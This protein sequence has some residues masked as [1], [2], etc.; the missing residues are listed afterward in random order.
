MTLTSV[1]KSTAGNLTEAYRLYLKYSFALIFPSELATNACKI[2]VSIFTYYNQVNI[3]T[4]I[5]QRESF[6]SGFLVPVSA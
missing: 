2:K 3:P 1:I 6:N 5:I 4:H